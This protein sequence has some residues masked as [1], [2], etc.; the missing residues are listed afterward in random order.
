MTFLFLIGPV[1]SP[2]EL[3]SSSETLPPVGPWCSPTE[4]TMPIGSGHSSTNRERGLTF[5]RS[6]IA[7]SPFASAPPLSWALKS[8]VDVVYVSL[9]IVG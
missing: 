3:N 5:L 9:E 1:Q 2:S 8:A 7:D 6:A 4:A